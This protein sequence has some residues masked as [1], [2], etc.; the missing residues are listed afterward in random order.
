LSTSGPSAKPPDD[1]APIVARD[2]FAA[3]GTLFQ[4]SLPT[5]LPLAVVALAASVSPIADEVTWSRGWWGVFIARTLIVLICYGAMLR[6]QLRF[7]AGERPN[8][9]QSL[10][11]AVR[12]LPAVLLVVA[13]WVLP[14]LPA[15]LRTAA[16]GFDVVALALTVFASA[17][18]VFVLPAWPA[19]VARGSL[20][21]AALAQS[22]Q[23]V[24]GRWLQLAGL[25]MLQLVGLLVFILLAGILIG[26]VMNLA[27]QGVNPTPA[28]LAAS[29]WLT[30]VVVSVPVLYAAATAVVT[31]RVIAANS[32]A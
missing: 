8:L 31:W 3:A 14:Y 18:I 28:A 6:Q 30:G 29:R 24:R 19:M 17:L 11:D 20:P 1:R 23:L 26:M 22:V 21:W 25:L 32:T 4:V 16:R 5:C 13:V 15:A 9:M 7:A 10:R 12:D 2:V 27:G